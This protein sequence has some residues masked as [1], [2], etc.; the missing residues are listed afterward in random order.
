MP[1][2]KK[3]IRGPKDTVVNKLNINTDGII[4]N[5][6]QKE[7]PSIIRSA[8]PIHHQMTA[9]ILLSILNSELIRTPRVQPKRKNSEIING[10]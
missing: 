10:K 9:Y 7:P 8:R 2:R 6:C 5:K 3:P 4:Q 1:V